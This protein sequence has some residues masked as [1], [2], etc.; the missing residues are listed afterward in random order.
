M[1]PCLGGFESL[2][3]FSGVSAGPHLG[4]IMMG[5]EKRLNMQDLVKTTKI[6]WQHAVVS[7]AIQIL[8]ELCID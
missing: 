6:F 7:S 1:E 8:T 5:K 2:F 3:M 4:M